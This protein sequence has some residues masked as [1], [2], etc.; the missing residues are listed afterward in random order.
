MARV[1][2]WKSR[3]PAILYSTRTSQRSEV[4]SASV[5]SIGMHPF[6]SVPGGLTIAIGGLLF[7]TVKLAEQSDTFPA[8][9]GRV[10]RSVVTESGATVTV[11]LKTPAAV[12]R[13]ISGSGS[14]QAADA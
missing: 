8:A 7:W 14:A 4:E 6:R 3:V 9:S 11:T 10:A 2:R 1:A 13:A 12:T 5:Y